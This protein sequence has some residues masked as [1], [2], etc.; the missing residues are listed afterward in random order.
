MELSDF[1]QLLGEYSIVIGSSSY[2]PILFIWDMIFILALS[3]IRFYMI[4][5]TNTRYKRTK[6]KSHLSNRLFI[7][8]ILSIIVSFSLTCIFNNDENVILNFA[9]CPIIGFFSSI[10][11]DYKF[12][13]KSDE[14]LTTIDGENAIVIEKPDTVQELN[15]K[16]QKT[17]SDLI[18]NP[19]DT[20][21]LSDTE[22]ISEDH[23]FFI[24]DKVNTLIEAVHLE[25][26]EIH[27]M[28]KKLNTLTDILDAIRET[29]KDD[30]KLK[31]EKMIYD[32]LTKGYA[33]P[34]EN[35][36]ITTDYRNYTAL[37]GN[38]DIKELYEKRYLNLHIHE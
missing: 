21:F 5:N 6:Y 19:T 10:V 15:K 23:N 33:T 32:C 9:I 3:Y 37:N 2:P 12:L 8:Y 18:K 11:F 27:K 20:D 13:N 17:F 4:K 36:I 22:M 38:G 16:I 25:A 1:T 31:L 28:D 35:R 26:M 14:V 30:K 29:M 24:K 7:C 34:E